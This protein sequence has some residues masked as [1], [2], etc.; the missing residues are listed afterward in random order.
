MGQEFQRK[1]GRFAGLTLLHIA[2]FKQIRFRKGAKC[3]QNT[4]FA[5]LYFIKLEFS[6]LIF[7]LLA[8]K[9]LQKSENIFDENR[10]TGLISLGLDWVGKNANAFNLYFDTIAIFHPKRRLAGMADTGRGSHDNKIARFKRK[11]LGNIDKGFN[12]RKNH[13]VGCA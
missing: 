5:D 11:C 7:G 8:H 13:H 10:K 6:A 1:Q 12:D 3:S 2:I 4:G 9:W